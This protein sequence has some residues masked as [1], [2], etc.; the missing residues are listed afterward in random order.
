MSEAQKGLSDLEALQMRANAVTDESLEST[1]RMMAMCEESQTTGAKTIEMLD[2]QGEQLNRVEGGLD[3][4]NAEM[5]EA[6]KHLTGMEKWCGLCVCPWNR[7]KKVKDI[8]ESKWENTGDGTV[9][10]KQPGSDQRDS[11]RGQGPYIQ[12]ITNDARED[13]MEE[14]LQESDH[15][16]Y[17]AARRLSQRN[18]QDL[19]RIEEGLD[20]INND[21]KQAEKALKRMG[22]CCGFC[23]NPW[24]KPENE[25]EG[26]NYD[27]TWKNVETGSTSVDHSRVRPKNNADSK[28]G[29]YITKYLDD[30]REEEM[31]EN[32]QQVSGILNNL[33]NMAMDMNSEL[34]NQNEQIDR[35]TIKATSNENRVTTANKKAVQLLK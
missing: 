28:G 33:K 24:K 30:N 17:L 6:E 13:E 20:I 34:E 21:M 12:R 29:K 4:I 9:V 16:D 8:D 10:R 32:L 2:H 3:N 11:E 26:M 15:D 22:Q 31:E 1:R 19:D 23:F 27:G 25:K 7:R 5:K 35:I 14:N 18:L